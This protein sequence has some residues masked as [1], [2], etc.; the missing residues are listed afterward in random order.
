MY[1]TYVTFSKRYKASLNLVTSSVKWK[2]YQVRVRIWNM[3]SDTLYIMPAIWLTWMV[4]VIL[5]P[6]QHRLSKYSLG[7]PRGPPFRRSWGSKL[8]S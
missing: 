8:F 5:V 1:F 7:T 6:L 2:W 3:K 4:V